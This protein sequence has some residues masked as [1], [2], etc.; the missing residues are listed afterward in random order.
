MID[1]IETSKK[2]TNFSSDIPSLLSLYSGADITDYFNY[3]F[4]EETWTA[5][6]EKHRTLRGDQGFPT[7]T[8]VSTIAGIICETQIAK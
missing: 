8:Y 6:C 4:N 1:F 3:G 7:K 2:L 5:Y